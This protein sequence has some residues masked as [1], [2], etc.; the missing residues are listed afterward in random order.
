M[1]RALKLERDGLY[2][3]VYEVRGQLGAGGTGTVYR[4]RHVLLEQERALKVLHPQQQADSALQGRLRLEASVFGRLKGEP[5]L[6][7]PFDMGF[8]ALTQTH[9]LAMELLEG[10]DLTSWVRERGPLTVEVVLEVMRQVARG[11][12]AAHGYVTSEG[13]RA[14]IVHRDLTPSNLFLIRPQHGV[15][16][17]KILDFGLADMLDGSKQGQRQRSGTPLYRSYEQEQGLPAG[18]PTDI[19]ALG[20]VVYFALTGTTYWESRTAAQLHDEVTVNP[21]EPPRAKLER[22][23]ERME[24]PEPFDAWLLRCLSR[25]P[26]RRFGSAGEALDELELCLASAPRGTPLVWSA[27]DSRRGQERAI[28][29]PS[30]WLRSRTVSRAEPEHFEP[31]PDASTA[32]Q[33]YVTEVHPVLKHAV[34]LADDLMTAA[35]HYLA[36]VPATR[37]ILDKQLQ[38]VRQAAQAYELAAQRLR[39]P[40]GI[41]AFAAGLEGATA[42]ELGPVMDEVWPA[43]LGLPLPCQPTIAAAEALDVLAAYSVY[44]AHWQTQRVGLHAALEVAKRALQRAEEFVEQQCSEPSQAPESALAAIDA[45]RSLVQGYVASA[46]TLG[47]AIAAFIEAIE[48]ASMNTQM[49]GLSAAAWRLAQPIEVMNE[50]YVRLEERSLELCVRISRAGGAEGR[51]WADGLKAVQSYQWYRVRPQLNA[52]LVHLIRLILSEEPRTLPLLCAERPAWERLRRLLMR[53]AVG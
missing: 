12:D 6:V 18:P 26:G 36:F 15:K 16:Q 44:S 28:A 34:R 31:P 49:D 38:G 20:L 10:R 29:L 19:W 4:A 42:L 47:G 1:Q 7:M 23:F 48:R 41:G 11:I 14:P 37:A 3:G 53:A 32:L 51:R 45:A 46:R 24:L 21:L 25:L 27:S 30:E 50:S 8:D 35:G 39:Q 17:V 33:Q 43:L 22:R 5:T 2:A 9:F 40:I 13:A 52:V